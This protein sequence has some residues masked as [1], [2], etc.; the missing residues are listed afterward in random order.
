MKPAA[1]WAAIVLL[2]IASSA[3]AQARPD[4]SGRWTAEPEPTPTRGGGAGGRGRPADMGSGWGSPIT[5]SQDANR[6]TVEYMFFGRGDMQPPLRFI[7]A[8]DGSETKN[9][10]M[11]G[12]GIQEQ[13]SHTAW[14]AN[15]L[16]ITTLHPFPNPAGGKPLTA[17][18]KQVLSLESP[19]SLVIETTRGGVLGGPASTS[20]T[21]YVK[22]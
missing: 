17:E 22:S 13:T 20:R 1:G 19:T 14:E 10:V 16:I 3:A 21:V 18:V 15:K 5:I 7:F 8:L 12:R 2:A 11:M 6:L 4:F 9:T